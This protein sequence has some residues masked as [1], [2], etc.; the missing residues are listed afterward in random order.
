MGKSNYSTWTSKIRLSGLCYKSHLTTT[1]EFIPLECKQWIKI[2]ALC[3]AIKSTICTFKSIFCPHEMC[4]LVR[5][6]ACAIYTNGK[7]LYDVC[8]DL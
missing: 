3:G 4:T 6:E 7:C 1:V 2:D 5:S 8:Q